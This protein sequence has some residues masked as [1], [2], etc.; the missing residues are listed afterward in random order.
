MISS[1]HFQGLTFDLQ[2]RTSWSPTPLM[3]SSPA[4]RT[5]AR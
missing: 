1:L 2:P 3:P 4:T 5:R